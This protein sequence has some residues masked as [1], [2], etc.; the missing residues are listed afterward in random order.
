[1]RRSLVVLGAAAAVLILSFF[2]LFAAEGSGDV[3]DSGSLPALTTTTT[4]PTPTT[5]T[6]MVTLRAIDGSN[7]K[8]ILVF[9]SVPNV[10]GLTF[11]QADT[12][13]SAVGLGAGETSSASK[14]SG[15]TATGTILAQSPAAG[16]QAETDQ[17]VQLTISGY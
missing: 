3:S 4:T 6:T 2:A 15:Q 16:S 7:G 8:A 17:V 5:V 12:V 10:V 11:A 1:V 13:L 14:P 9:V